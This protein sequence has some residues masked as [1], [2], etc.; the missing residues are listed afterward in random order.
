VE[1][2]FASFL[3]CGSEVLR[4]DNSLDCVPRNEERL[5]FDR[6]ILLVRAGVEFNPQTAFVGIVERSGKMT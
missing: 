2:E 1:A 6:R 4:D 3:H 5:Q